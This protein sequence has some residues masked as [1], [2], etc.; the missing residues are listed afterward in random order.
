[1]ICRRRCK[2]VG[3]SDDGSAWERSNVDRIDRDGNSLSSSTKVEEGMRLTLREL[4]PQITLRV[5]SGGA[6]GNL[7]NSDLVITLVVVLVGSCSA[8]ES[9]KDVTTSRTLPSSAHSYSDGIVT[10]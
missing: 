9:N 7:Y 2:V 6:T 5:T 8:I 10:R 3:D 4:C 1:V